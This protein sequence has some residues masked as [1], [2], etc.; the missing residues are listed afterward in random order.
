MPF[1]VR[2]AD[3]T[4]SDGNEGDFE[5]YKKDTGEHVSCHQ[6][7]EDAQVSAKIAER[8]SDHS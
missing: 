7:K 2:K 8:E 1:G 5:V 3:C 4:D 6:S